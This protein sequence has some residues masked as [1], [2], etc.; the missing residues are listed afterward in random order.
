M[1]SE[2]EPDTNAFARDG[3][4]PMSPIYGNGNSNGASLKSRSKRSLHAHHP[5]G[6]FSERRPIEKFRSSVNK[7][8][9]MKRS[10]TI[11]A[12]VGA[13]AEPGIDPRRASM[14][15][16]YRTVHKVRIKLAQ[17]GDRVNISSRNV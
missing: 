8:I 7:I 17:S 13:G 11:L 6:A 10:T 12:A 16:Q 4:T 1:S 2:G 14:E 15:L 9:A 3:E 5:P